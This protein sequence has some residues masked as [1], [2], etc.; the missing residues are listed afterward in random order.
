MAAFVQGGDARD[1][2]MPAAQC[3]HAAQ[4]GKFSARRA[5]AGAE[6]PCNPGT[7]PPDTRAGSASA[8]ADTV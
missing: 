2:D 7:M 8:P 5:P 4:P 6:V 1:S 3:M